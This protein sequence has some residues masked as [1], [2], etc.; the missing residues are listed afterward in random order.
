MAFRHGVYKQEVPTSVIAPS[1]SESGLPV[2]IGTA[3]VFMADSTC[4]NKPVLVHTYEEAVKVFGYS[5]N[6]KDWTLCEFMY[7]QFV[8]Y[9]QSPCVLVNVFDPARHKEEVSG[10]EYA[11]LNGSVNLGQN[12]IQ[13]DSQSLYYD[14]EGNAHIASTGSVTISRITKAKPSLVT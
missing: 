1:Q 12:I 3:P 4:I 14:D 8:L 13:A 10:A 11:S 6:W 5:E 2:I 9:G 7:S